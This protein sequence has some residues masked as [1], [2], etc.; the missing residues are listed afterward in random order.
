[1]AHVIKHC[2]HNGIAT[3]EPTEEAEQQWVAELAALASDSKAFYT[4]CTPGYFNNEGDNERK[5]YL[6]E[7]QYGGGPEQFFAILAQ[8]RAEGEF[9]GMRLGQ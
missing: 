1:M 6:L 9:R 2:P 3:V 7:G 5:N 4:D 8:W